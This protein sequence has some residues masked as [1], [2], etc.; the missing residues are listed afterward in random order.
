MRRIIIRYNIGFGSHTTDMDVEDDASE[1]EI[2]SSVE[3]AVMERL[4]WSW[5]EEGASD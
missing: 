2:E 3:E 1:E 5:R 4:D